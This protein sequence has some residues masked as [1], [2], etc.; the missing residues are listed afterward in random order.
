MKTI[1]MHRFNIQWFARV[2]M[3]ALFLIAGVRKIFAFKAT[4]G[5]FAAIGLPFAEVVTALVI[6]IEAGGAIALILGWRLKPLALL[7]AIYTVATAL[8]GHKFWAADPAQFSAQLNNFFKN[9]AIAGG[10]LLLAAQ[11]D[12]SSSKA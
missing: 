9:I 12:T 8:I 1:T 4:V 3:S 7:L 6:V 11:P 2:L 5:Y 10:F